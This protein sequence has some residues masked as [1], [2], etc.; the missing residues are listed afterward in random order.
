MLLKTKEQCIGFEMRDGCILSIEKWT[1]LG[2]LIIVPKTQV[3]ALATAC[4]GLT[5]N[6]FRQG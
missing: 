2:D 1:G 3:G 6:S 4:L 5:W